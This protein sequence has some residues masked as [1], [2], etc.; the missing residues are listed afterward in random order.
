[1]SYEL[2][3]EIT[4]IIA[5]MLRTGTLAQWQRARGSTSNLYKE[6]SD[7]TGETRALSPQEESSYIAARMPATFAANLRAFEILSEFL[8]Q[9]NP[10]SLLDLGSGPGTASL[11]ALNYL[12]AIKEVTF[13]DRSL[14]FLEA[15]KSFCE[16]GSFKTNLVNKNLTDPSTLPSADLVIA[17]YSTNELS[18]NALPS[19]IE[20]AWAATN[21]IFVVVEPGTKAGFRNILKIRD[22]LINRGAKI[23]APCPHSAECP[24]NNT[25]K[26]CHFRVRFNRSRLH[27]IVKDAV[28]SHEDEPFSFMAFSKS[29]K[30]VTRERLTSFP[31]KE[32][33]FIKAE[34]C[35]FDGKLTDRRFLK[36]NKDEYE[37]VKNLTWGD[38]L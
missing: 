2:P 21:S 34:I 8:D 18:E 26:W 35:G 5:D 29:D 15:A 30:F 11:A 1:M 23:L 19:F 25:D 4:A 9:N 7:S 14:T 10:T 33:G 22:L 12:N 16:G 3:P 28:L 20:R 38:G 17:S 13:V 24:M 31:R 6:S 32:K 36:R 37:R 27:K